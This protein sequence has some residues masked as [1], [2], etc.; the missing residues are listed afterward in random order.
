VEGLPY[1]TYYGDGTPI[2]PEVVE[3]IQAAYRAEMVVFPWEPGDVL[4]LDN[5][6]VAHGRRP[7]TGERQVVVAMAEPQSGLD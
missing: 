3:Q 1:N 4:L 6:T 5:L 2:E 7:Y